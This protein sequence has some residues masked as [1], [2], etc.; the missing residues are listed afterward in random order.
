[1]EETEGHGNTRREKPRNKKNG[2]RVFPPSGGRSQED[3]GR[4]DTGR[5]HTDAGVGGG[6]AGK[7]NADAG[8]GG[9]DA[10]R[11]GG[12]P[13]KGGG[14]AGMG[15]GEAGM[16]GGDANR[17]GGKADR[18]TGDAG[19]GG[20]DAGKGG[21]NAGRGGGEAGRGVDNAGRGGGDAGRGGRGAGRGSGGA[22]WGGGDAGRGGGRYLSTQ[23]QLAH[24]AFRG[25]Y[26]EALAKK[27]YIT[28][29]KLL[30]GSDIR[31]TQVNSSPLFKYINKVNLIVEKVFFYFWFSRHIHIFAEL[32]RLVI[33]FLLS[34]MERNAIE[35]LPGR[36]G[37]TFEHF[38]VGP[39][40]LEPTIMSHFNFELSDFPL[41]AP[42]VYASPS[43]IE[44]ADVL[45]AHRDNNAKLEL[46][47]LY[48]KQ[49][50]IDIE[51]GN[52]VQRKVYRQF[53]ENEAAMIK[54][55]RVEATGTLFQLLRPEPS[56]RDRFDLIKWVAPLFKTKQYN[57][58]IKLMS[59]FD[60][61]KDFLPLLHELSSTMVKQVKPPS[62]QDQ[63]VLWPSDRTWTSNELALLLMSDVKVVLRNEEIPTLVACSLGLV[64]VCARN[65][66]KTTT[67]RDLA[68]TQLE[69][70]ISED[71]PVE[72]RHFFGVF[73]TMLFKELEFVLKEDADKQRKG[74]MI[75]SMDVN[76]PAW[77]E[78]ILSRSVARS[79]KSCKANSFLFLL[80]FSVLFARVYYRDCLM[81][82]IDQ[83][84]RE[85]KLQELSNEGR[86]I[87]ISTDEVLTSS[88]LQSLLNSLYLLERS[89]SMS[90]KVPS[91]ECLGVG[92]FLR[93]AS[94]ELR[95][96]II[97]QLEPVLQHFQQA[98]GAVE[99]VNF[100]GNGDNILPASDEVAP[101]I[102]AY[103]V[104]S[105]LLDTYLA[106]STTTSKVWNVVDLLYDLEE[107]MRE[108]LVS[109]SSSKRSSGY[110]SISIL[111]VIVEQGELMEKISR[112]SFAT[113]ESFSDSSIATNRKTSHM[114]GFDGGLP[115]SQQLQEELLNSCRELS[116]TEGNELEV[117]R[118]VMA[119]L[120]MSEGDANLLLQSKRG[121]RSAPRESLF[122]VGS[123]TA[124]TTTT[125]T[126]A[127]N[128]PEPIKHML[129]EQLSKI[130][131]G[132]SV[133][134]TLL[135]SLVKD[136]ANVKTL[137][138]LMVQLKIDLASKKFYVMVDQD[139]CFK[140]PTEFSAQD[141]FLLE[142]SIL[143]EEYHVVAAFVVSAIQGL[144][145]ASQVTDCL[146]RMFRDT[147]DRLLSR[148][149]LICLSLPQ[150]SE[151]V[152]LIKYFCNKVLLSVT[153]KSELHRKLVTVALDQ[154]LSCR[155]LLST[156]CAADGSSFSDMGINIARFGTHWFEDR[157]E[158]VP[159]RVAADPTTDIVPNALQQVFVS[160]E[161]ASRDRK[162]VSNTD[163]AVVCI[164]RKAYVQQLLQREFRYD[165]HMQKP[166][167]QSPESLKLKKTLELLAADLYKSDVHFVME[168][169]QN[170]DDNTY[171]GHTT[172]TIKFVLDQAYLL[173]L[174]NE[175]GF[176]EDNIG[177]VCNVGGSTKKGKKGNIGQKGIGFKSVFSVSDFP[178]IHSNG[179]HIM[180]DRH[181]SMIEPI[182]IE[183]TSCW[184]SS[185]DESSGM[186]FE[187]CLKLKL[188]DSALNNMSA[189]MNN[190]E[191]IFQGK[192]LLFLNKLS[193]MI[194]SHPR[195]HMLTEHRKFQLSNNWVS[196][197]EMQS[198]SS[199]RG[200]N[201]HK[202]QEGFWFIEQFK[203]APVVL[204]NEVELDE[205]I[206]AL[207]FAF[208]E[209]E[210]RFADQDLPL[211][212]EDDVASNNKQCVS[213]KVLRPDISPMLLPLY[214]F[215]P[216]EMRYFQFIL[217]ADFLLS[218]SREQVLENNAWNISLLSKVPA[219]FI[220]LLSEMA[221]W[222]FEK[223]KSTDKCPR[224]MSI[225]ENGY[226]IHLEPSDL[227]QYVPSESVD[228]PSDFKHVTRLIYAGL[229]NVSF[230]QAWDGEPRSAGQ[231]LCISHLSF[232]PCTY[233]NKEQFDLYISPA[234][235]YRIFAKDD[236]DY[237]LDSRLSHQLGVPLF[238]GHVVVE[239]MRSLET[240]IAA[241]AIEFEVAVELI[242][243]LL[244]CLKEMQREV[245]TM[246][247]SISKGFA[248]RADFQ[249]W[250]QI[251]RSL[252]IWPTQDNKFVS[253]EHQTLI[254]EGP[255]GGAASSLEHMTKE[256]RNCL[257]IFTGHLPRLHDSMFACAKNVLFNGHTQLRAFLLDNLKSGGKHTG[258][259]NI[260][261]AE[262]VLQSIIKPAYESAAGA[263]EDRVTYCAFLAFLYHC[264]QNRR[265]VLTSSLKHFPFDSIIFPTLRFRNQL[266]E[267]DSKFATRKASLKRVCDEIHLGA[268]F[269]DSAVSMLQG[270]DEKRS[271]VVM[272]DWCVLDPLVTA[273]AFGKPANTLLHSGALSAAAIRAL[274]DDI[275]SDEMNKWK[276]FLLKRGVVN[277]FGIYAPESLNTTP[278]HAC[279]PTIC[280][281]LAR[282]L[283]SAR[284][285]RTNYDTD[286]SIVAVAPS[287]CTYSDIEW[288]AE[289]DSDVVPLY[290]HFHSD[291]EATVYSVDEEAHHLLWCMANIIAATRQ[292]IYTLNLQNAELVDRVFKGLN[293]SAWFPI[294]NYL[295]Y[296]S[297][298]RKA[299]VSDHEKFLLTAPCNIMY[300]TGKKKEFIL[301][302]HIPYFPTRY[303]GRSNVSDVYPF[304]AA[305]ATS[306]PPLAFCVGLYGWMMT[307]SGYLASSSGF[308]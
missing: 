54:C 18:G 110:A 217:Q 262:T 47:R 155:L 292:S 289:Q 56:E 231:L 170:A 127:H 87:S 139:D 160:S 109:A 15:G 303:E 150:S 134:K 225:V 58:M 308:V 6:D 161:G 253:L 193:H 176:Q 136:Q 71:I 101:K 269:T 36:D 180:F 209:T 23:G 62:D 28:T 55:V 246:S 53:K 131:C 138:D 11:G 205:T 34:D 226:E 80:M 84:P 5:G 13:G 207:G 259:L 287:L 25:L 224:L 22:G 116:S 177:A 158:E 104:L 102:E 91:F 67:E 17:G 293:T 192:L 64:L 38:N 266:W 49:V 81:R 245:M 1:M 50:H 299:L 258:G 298:A 124:Q 236:D 169:L 119:T 216:T 148:V 113:N 86:R 141:T 24:D 186:F 263:K 31:I 70:A 202:S 45:R 144:I 20:D 41:D 7:G 178:E 238:D 165:E 261:T 243:G 276:E 114:A 271:A 100:L 88:P 140:L 79:G 46:Q 107:K 133:R 166:T 93:V 214:A 277:G 183:D 199:H 10:N 290:L 29:S 115:V 286:A 250:F 21:G 256:Q 229:Q 142:S 99:Q 4:A 61:S 278:W 85:H 239:A 51:A 74:R 305:S 242:T 120:H 98:I 159:V 175:I 126:N 97:E 254:V 237:T 123:T 151:C 121:V 188:N 190:I 164:E 185:L 179:F 77:I 37:I 72:I 2:A 172:P 128:I 300:P 204:R 149:L 270:A 152:A 220:D 95:H 147:N 9:G 40:Y 39:L 222:C 137:L 94:H 32:E 59:S 187:T 264:E 125:A 145:N 297:S 206:V 235:D 307:I 89:F 291:S 42:V 117:V 154:P 52:Y 35:F 198:T 260:I 3:S 295:Y 43:W 167:M 221:S 8:R 219:L 274:F 282:I 78:K 60:A 129:V 191:D 257:D 230:L 279:C 132:E 265:D 244:L 251:L 212:M 195:S 200:S 92:S 208:K 296:Y 168:L 247:K 65:N 108:Y 280:I 143:N 162:T 75:E 12:D 76:I 174:N 181:E 66:L 275:R 48:G 82:S 194:Y 171:D 215:L 248:V 218:T 268:E 223:G 284:F 103:E 302:P 273:F 255:M 33:Q 227:L 249:S 26:I 69:D 267:A 122:V 196:I 252:H 184:P 106:E 304:L 288:A 228:M 182:W 30:E 241:G 163:H 173:V 19:K 213:I 285:V 135:W 146:Q 90:L 153:S 14:E 203:F 57:S 301:G 44:I 118:K 240:Q 189:L 210:R 112:L 73:L 63:E 283:R 68:R 294:D 105:E 306:N 130:K 27:Q 157:Q 201:V 111:S 281:M 197:Q 211:D 234:L 272:E 96:V 156:V 16:G 232:N 83:P 233:F